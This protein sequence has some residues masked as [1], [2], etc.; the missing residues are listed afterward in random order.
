MQV[1][2][3]T[4]TSAQTHHLQGYHLVSRSHG[5]T[6]EIASSLSTW[7][8]S[9]AS[10][11]EESRTASSLNVFPVG[12]GK[13]ALSRTFFGGPEYSS[14][15]GLQV[16]TRF[17][18]FRSDQLAGYENDFTAIARI[19]LAVGELRLQSEISERLPMVDFPASSVIASA[20]LQ[21]NQHDDQSPSF[22]ELKHS[23]QENRRA[24]V[25]GC[26][27]PLDLMERVI[28]SVPVQNRLQ[29]SF[30]TG[31]NPSVH[32]PFLLHCLPQPNASLQR[33]LDEQ[34]IVTVN[35]PL[36]PVH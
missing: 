29:I 36:E 25:V 16:V 23:V 9:H 1:D 11:A 30:T 15:G 34:G 7:G 10:L 17:L 21:G 33:R 35:A 2:Q 8:P 20:P 13:F 12:N 6:S 31:L 28:R 3:A 22:A 19:A 32:R 4:F 27:N 18:V 5:I 26:A 14:R 24:A